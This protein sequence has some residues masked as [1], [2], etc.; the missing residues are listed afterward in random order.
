MM[1]FNKNLK[2]QRTN[3][4]QSLTRQMKTKTMA[5]KF[6][7]K[8]FEKLKE[9]CEENFYPILEY[10]EKYYL[11]LKK[12]PNSKFRV[13]TRFA[14]SFWNLYDRVKVKCHAARSNNQIEAWHKHFNES[15]NSHPTISKF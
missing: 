1:R 3:L 8:C 14:V 5:K 4:V 6:V 10:F 9:E 7:F 13:N 12:T 2:I 15:I 11:G